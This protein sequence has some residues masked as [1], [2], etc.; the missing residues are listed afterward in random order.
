MIIATQ[1]RQLVGQAIIA[2]KIVYHL[3]LEKP[4]SPDLG[5]CRKIS[6]DSQFEY[7][8]KLKTEHSHC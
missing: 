2:L 7:K 5:E 8:E 4:I 3:R 1:D 6:A